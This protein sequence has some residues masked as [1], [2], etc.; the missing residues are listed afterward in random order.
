MVLEMI[1][2]LGGFIPLD[3]SV[4]AKIVELFVRDVAVKQEIGKVLVL[5][6]VG[7]FELVG[8]EIEPGKNLLVWW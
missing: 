8:V 3:I 5:R 2:L 4:L 7:G 1:P 6:A